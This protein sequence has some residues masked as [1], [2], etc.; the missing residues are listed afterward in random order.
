M[1]NLKFFSLSTICKIQ[2]ERFC[3]LLMREIFCLITCEISAIENC[4]EEW[5][6]F[7]G[8]FVCRSRTLNELK[9]KRERERGEEIN[10]LSLSKYGL[11]VAL[12]RTNERLIDR[13]TISTKKQKEYCRLPRESN[14]RL[15]QAV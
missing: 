1:N 5:I 9:K 11:P 13:P 10:S 12:S 15:I 14:S 3:L 4:R 8:E 7:H 2:Q 6:V